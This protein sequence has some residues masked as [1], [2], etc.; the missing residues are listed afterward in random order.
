MSPAR[1]G[2]AAFL[3]FLPLATP[4][5]RGE[6]EGQLA[7][8]WEHS[9]GSREWTIHL[10]TDVRWHDGVPVT[11][12]DVKFTFD[13]FKHPGVITSTSN[14]GFNQIESVVVLDDYSFIMTYKPG[15]IWHFYWYPG[16]WQIFYPKHLL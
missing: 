12:H 1:R 15:S 10:R 4:N 14:T 2:S 3:V 6:L 5:E 11:A 13:L 16:Y 8:S 9:P 7:K